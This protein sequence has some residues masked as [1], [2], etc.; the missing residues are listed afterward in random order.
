MNMKSLILSVF[1][2]VFHCLVLHAQVGIGTT[3]PDAS[4][5]LDVTA[6]DKG[7]LVPRMLV[8]ERIAI[9]APAEGLLIYQTDDVSGFYFYNGTQ[10]VRLMDKSRDG[11]PIGAVFAFP[12][13]TLPTGYLSC[14]GSAVSR[15]TYAELF[16]VIGSTYGNGDGATTFNLP[17]YRGEFLR[18]LDN[19]SGTDPD[20]ATR[21][22][23]GDGVVGDVVGTKQI[24]SNV[25]HDHQIDAPATNSMASGTHDHYTLGYTLT[26]NYSGNHNHSGNVSGTTY[27]SGSPV[28]VPYREVTVEDPSTFDADIIIR[29]LRPGSG[30]QSV[31]SGSHSHNF[32]TSFTTNIG[33]NHN[34]NINVPVRSTN[35][36]GNHLHSIDIP[37]FTS[38][39][40]GGNESRPTNV[41]VIWC[42]K[43]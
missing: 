5:A 22:D 9:S 10:W 32:N 1:S 2:L 11:V 3:T 33:G 12:S 4:S 21:T 37:T 38:G 13:A 28:Q 8:A 26:T 20:A 27:A 23:R 42:I 34:H 17:D 39:A 29:E 25:Q 40:Q 6:N 19:G 14:D 24:F 30:F 31:S 18:G 7:I 16:A 43:Y 41:N 35:T 36:A 15:N